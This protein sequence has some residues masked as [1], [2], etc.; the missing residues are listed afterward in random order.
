M[1]VVN[2]P[3]N[4]VA[5]YLAAVMVT[6]HWRVRAAMWIQAGVLVAAALLLGVYLRSAV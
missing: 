6:S 1:P 5:G 3:A 4:A 2:F